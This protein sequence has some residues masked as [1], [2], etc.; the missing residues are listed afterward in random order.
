VVVSKYD[1]CTSL[2][3]AQTWTLVE[4][5]WD[6][7][8][9]HQQAMTIGLNQR[10]NPHSPIPSSATLWKNCLPLGFLTCAR[11]APSGGP[12]GAAQA[13]ETH[14]QSAHRTNLLSMADH[15][16]P[17]ELDWF[18]TSRRVC[19]ST[20]PCARHWVIALRISHWD[21]T[22]HD[23]RQHSRHPDFAFVRNARLIRDLLHRILAKRC[24]TCS[25]EIGWFGPTIH[26]WTV[27][28]PCRSVETR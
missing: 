6:A 14:R 27:V 15:C 12:W 19:L 20:T 21:K 17:V 3:S 13:K 25:P 26:D 4:Q 9:C 7:R 16:T 10:G 28:I 23:L 8:R 22:V 5:S 1:F 24:K 11:G 2:R 18:E